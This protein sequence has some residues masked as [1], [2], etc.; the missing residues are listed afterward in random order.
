MTTTEPL[1]ALSWKLWVYTNHDCNLSCS[2]CVA[3][4]T[5]RALR[6]A[7]GLENACCIVD[8]AVDLGVF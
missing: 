5:P 2:Y 4:S 3:E 1:P 6:N 8:E 7:I